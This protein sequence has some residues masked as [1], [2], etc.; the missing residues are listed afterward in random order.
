MQRGVIPAW[1]D[2][3][4]SAAV[5]I[6][7]DRQVAVTALVGD[8]VD[9]DAPQPLE[10]IDV[11]I[12]VGADTGDDR[13]DG[14]PGD[15]Q[16]LDDCALG[17]VH[18][19]PRRLIVEVPG[20]PG[21]VT[22]PRDLSHGRAMSTT[23][24]PRSVSLDEH[25]GRAQ[26]QRPPAPSALTAVIAR[27]LPAAPPAPPAR[28]SHR[29][30]RDHDGI[31]TVVEEHVLD[32][33]ARQPEGPLP[34]AA[35]PHP[36]LPPVPEPSDSPERRKQAGCHRGWAHSAT[37]GSVRR[38]EKFAETVRSRRRRRWRRGRWRRGRRR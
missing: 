21:A 15:A 13:A 4:Q 11:P 22:S 33:R 28:S 25:P 34:Y 27:R 23:T 16:Q 30:R 24:H 7:D 6:D 37:H 12:D 9:P 8:L 31:N 17:H 18:R 14:A 36:V 1:C 20:V 3:H 38:A 2:P 32:D 5:M 10:P 29:P 19:Q 35:V 26:I